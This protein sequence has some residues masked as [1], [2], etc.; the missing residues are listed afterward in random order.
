MLE[1]KLLGKEGGSLE[2]EENAQPEDPRAI[3]LRKVYRAKEKSQ[4]EK[5]RETAAEG[6]AVF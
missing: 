5:E 4:V 1:K 2:K 3:S 6:N